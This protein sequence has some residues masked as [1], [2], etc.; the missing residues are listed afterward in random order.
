MFLSTFLYW[1]DMMVHLS[2]WT[3]GRVA[4]SILVGSGSQ[5]AVAHNIIIIII[6]NIIINLNPRGMRMGSREGST[7][8]NFIVYTVHLI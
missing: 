7:M 6:I 3:S 2:L 4:S 1:R 5:W 8:R